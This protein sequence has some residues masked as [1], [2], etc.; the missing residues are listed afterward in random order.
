MGGS[1]RKIADDDEVEQL[2]R[3]AQDESL[4]KLNLNS[5][6][7]R[8]SA[9]AVID[10]D[11]DRRFQALKKQT[12]IDNPPREVDDDLF[13]RFGALKSSLPSHNRSE[14]KIDFPGGVSANQ[15][16]REDEESE[17]DEVDKV[18]KWAIDAA[19]LDP[20]DDDDGADNGKKGK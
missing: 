19:R 2:L 16:M 15:E 10:P 9:S 5:H 14:I 3:A 12:K 8:A 11:L 20:D 6:M 17:E 4:L 7:A 13:A 1:G 18:I